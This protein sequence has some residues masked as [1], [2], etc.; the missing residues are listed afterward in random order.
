MN[1]VAS[2]TYTSK[3]I[4]TCNGVK[5]ILASGASGG[6]IFPALAFL[7]K[8]LENPKCQ[9]LLILPKS[10]RIKNIIPAGFKI[11]YVS[12]PGENLVDSVKGVLS[13]LGLVFKF[14]PDVVIGFGTIVSFPVVMLS[15]FLRA[16]T[17]IH[18]QNVFPGKANQV[19]A[20]FADKIAVSFSQSKIYFKN[21]T[22]KLALTGNPLR[23]GL[24]RIEKNTARQVFGFT[25]DKFTVLVSGGS[26]ASH[27]INL[28]FFKAVG[29]L[30]D[31]T[32]LQVIHLCGQKDFAFLKRGYVDLAVTAAVYSFYE[33]MQF[34]YSAC[35]L[36]VSRAGAT[37]I[38]EIIYFQIPAI[39][40]PYPYAAGHQS[41]NA[42]ILSEEGSAVVIKDEDLAAEPLK[43]KLEDYL[44]GNVAL[45]QAQAGF[46]RLKQDN[47]AQRLVKEAFS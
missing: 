16:K 31:R 18:E 8:A 29:L 25:P 11:E 39:L 34:A 40:V 10:C 2:R 20:Y 15:W 38:A 6:H 3:N 21:N 23:K 1:P 19:L 42:R 12:L 36:A 33:P 5:V 35:D 46:N 27:K 30:R 47:A 14:H 37:S 4:P 28:E 9:A 17:I 22:S 24:I 13:C 44:G 32:S 41:A 26:Q 45:R 7:E 43:Q